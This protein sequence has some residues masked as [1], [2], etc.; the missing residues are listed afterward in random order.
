MNNERKKDANFILGIASHIFNIL[1]YVAIGVV[2]LSVLVAFIVFLVNVTVDEMLL[3]PYMQQI[4]D[5]TGKVSAFAI[6]LGNGAS[7]VK[8]ASEVTLDNIKSVIYCF[9]FVFCA[10]LIVLIP[11]F[12]FLGIMLEAFSKNSIFE[13]KNYQMV[14]YIGITTILS[15]VIIG[16]AESIVNYN[17][18]KTFITN[19]DNV[20]LRLGV[21]IHIVLIGVV[22]LILGT[23]IKMIIENHNKMISSET[24]IVKLD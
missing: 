20:T 5:E 10:T 24:N 15:G 23:V 1:F 12:R 11:I 3:P 4:H 8:P 21:N 2:A 22:I 9:L 14:N 6:N 13:S 18:F 7:I 19:V 16:F 17:L